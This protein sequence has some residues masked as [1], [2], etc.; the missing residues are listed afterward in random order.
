LPEDKVDNIRESYR[1]ALMG[2]LSTEDFTKIVKAL[3]KEAKK[4]KAWAVK[5]AFSLTL[6][7][8]GDYDLDYE[9]PPDPFEI[10]LGEP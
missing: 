2:A 8:L 5:L 1:G 7:K 6:S 4:G 10:T 9:P 3:V